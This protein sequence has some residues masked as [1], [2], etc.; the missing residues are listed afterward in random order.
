MVLAMGLIT[1]SIALMGAVGFGVMI[2]IMLSHAMPTEVKAAEGVGRWGPVG[3]FDSLCLRVAELAVDLFGNNLETVSSKSVD[4]AGAT[5]AAV[6]GWKTTA[7]HVAIIMDGNRRYGQ[8]A[9]GDPL[10]GHWDG[11]QTLVDCVSWC[12]ELG[13]EVLTVYAFSTE[14]WRRP[15]EEVDLLMQIFCKYAARCEEEAMA[16]DVRIKVLATEAERLPP[17]VRNAIASMEA[18]TAANRGLQFNLCVSYGAR[19][20]LARAA[21]RCCAEV[22]AGTLA[23]GE[24][25]EARLAARLSSGGLPDPDVVIRTSGERRLSNFLLFETAY[26][27]LFFLDKCWPELQRADLEDVLRSYEARARR[28]GA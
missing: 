17:S 10:K 2:G 21:R 1:S 25:D 20:D 22:A 8:A 11:G 14:N 28:F 26:A 5:S 6:P 16:H 15:P 18:T 27:E 9:H 24:V 7:K 23:V 13:V 12:R 19:S 4:S 3:L